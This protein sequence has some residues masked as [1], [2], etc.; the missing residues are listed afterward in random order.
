MAVFKK[1]RADEDK[2]NHENGNPGDVDFQRM[3]K[4]WRDSSGLTEMPNVVSKD[5][6]TICV[7]K[8]PIS[9]KELKKLDHDRCALCFALCMCNVRGCRWL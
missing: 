5:K 6:I 4:L 1:E 9:S 3:I 8:R 7:R 2:R